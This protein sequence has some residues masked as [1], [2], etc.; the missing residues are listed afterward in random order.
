[1]LMSLHVVGK[2][3]IVFFKISC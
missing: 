1:M 3:L 2:T